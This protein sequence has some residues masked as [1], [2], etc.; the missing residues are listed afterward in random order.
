VFD[1]D[2][3]AMQGLPT[4]GGGAVLDQEI[5]GRFAADKLGERRQVAALVDDAE[6]VLLARLPEGLQQVA[7]ALVSRGVGLRTDTPAFQCGG[8]LR[9]PARSG[10]PIPV[11]L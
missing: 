2:A 5:E 8:G 4:L 7:N 11:V 10:R 1:K 6:A 9:E 3:G